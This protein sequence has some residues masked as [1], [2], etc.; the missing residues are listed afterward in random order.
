M[1]KNVK[2]VVCNKKNAWIIS[3]TITDKA[4]YCRKCY[5]EKILK[6]KYLTHF[7]K[8]CGHKVNTCMETGDRDVYC[9]GCLF[10]RKKVPIESIKYF[11][12]CL[13]KS[14]EKTSLCIQDHICDVVDINSC[15]CYFIYSEGYR[16]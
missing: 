3:P 1:N 7:C 10:Q 5:C 12:N 14:S 11:Y 4:I 16:C 2:C 9:F 13:I 15:P 8:K 6:L